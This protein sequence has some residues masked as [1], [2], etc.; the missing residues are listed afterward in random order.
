MKINVKQ[1]NIKVSACNK[2][3]Q[4]LIGFMFKKKKITNGLIF[5]KCNAI[6]TFFMY[7]PIDVVMTDINNNILFTFE[8]LLPNKIILPKKGVYNTYELPVGTIKKIIKKNTN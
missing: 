2:W 8:N 6:H 7:Q 1:L 3:Y 4:K 5:Y